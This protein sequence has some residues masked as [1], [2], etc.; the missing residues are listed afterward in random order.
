MPPREDLLS[1][2]HTRSFD[3]DWEALGLQDE[4]LAALQKQLI[5]D[6]LA[7][8]VIPGA[9]GLRKLRLAP[10]GRGK[11]GGLRVCYAFLPGFG[12]IVLTLVYGK[13]AKADLELAE[14]KAVARLLNEIEK[15]LRRR[16]GSP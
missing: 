3:S 13:R 1:F 6:P 16:A 5:E 7:G 12:I 8:D 4:E 15:R 11:S 9:G 10:A 2:F 14:K